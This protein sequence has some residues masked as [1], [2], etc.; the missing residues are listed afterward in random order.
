MANALS[1]CSGLCGVGIRHRPRQ[2]QNPPSGLETPY[3]ALNGR[4]PGV[5][6]GLRGLTGADLGIWRGRVEQRANRS[7][8]QQDRPSC[9]PVAVLAP[10]TLRVELPDCL[11]LDVPTEPLV[12][13]ATRMR[14]DDGRGAVVT[15]VACA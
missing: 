15:G 12:A 8:V 6:L 5:A 14:L 4:N 10:L 11:C 9:D 2:P 1:A 3:A 13:G 7:Q